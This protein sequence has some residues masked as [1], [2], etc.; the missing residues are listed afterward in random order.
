M[1]GVKGQIQKASREDT[2]RHKLWQVIRQRAGQGFTIVDLL[3]SVPGAK[4]S[5]L[6]KWLPGLC[7]HGF[8]RECGKVRGAKGFENKY[9]I[10]KESRTRPMVCDRCG[11][12]VTAKKCEAEF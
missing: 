5:N 11:K 1:P 8:I 10:A 6:W 9:V 7:R 4:T 3:V 2:I 12:A